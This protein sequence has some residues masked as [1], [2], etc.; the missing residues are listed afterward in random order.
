MID[1]SWALL[2]ICVLSLEGGSHLGDFPSTQQRSWQSG[3]IQ[4]LFLMTNLLTRPLALGVSSFHQS[5][6]TLILNTKVDPCVFCCC[7]KKV[8]KFSSSGHHNILCHSSCGAGFGCSASRSLLPATPGTGQAD[9]LAGG[10]ASSPLW[11]GEFSS[12]CLSPLPCWLSGVGVGGG[13]G[14]HIPGQVAPS[15][16]KPAMAHQTFLVLNL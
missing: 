13:A 12:L 16:L 14:T 8:H 7:I 5:I 11:S 10:S 4:C 15:N 3:G 9:F 6:H 2:C 1:K